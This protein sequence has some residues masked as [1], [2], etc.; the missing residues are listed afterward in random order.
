MAKSTQKQFLVKVFGI[1]GYFA[2][3]SGGNTSAEVRKV[4]D[5]G[6]LIPDV[7]STPS[8]TENI[9]CGRHFDFQRDGALLKS[10]RK[11]VGIGV[12]TVSVTPTN[13]SLV[14]I[15]PPDTYVDC[16]LVG[17]RRSDYSSEGS[18]AAT[19]ELEFAPSDV[20]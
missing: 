20:V 18:D 6:S 12:Y 3:F 8:Q 4:Y 5:G 19:Y 9:V 16:R 17:L 11:N 15:G 10:L 2:S 7:L 13:A 14:P 1:D